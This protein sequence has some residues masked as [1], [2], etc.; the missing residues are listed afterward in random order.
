MQP[1]FSK[2]QVND[3]FYNNYV[4]HYNYFFHS[5]GG[6]LCSFSPCI[7]QV[8]R[9]CLKLTDLGFVYINTYECLQEELSVQYKILPVLDLDCL[10]NKVSITSNT[11][12][13]KFIS[14]I[15][16]IITFLQFSTIVFGR[17]LINISHGSF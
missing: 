15:N 11:L 7:E 12:K 4:D 16:F 5:S 8:Q 17:K 9:T 2:L 13:I 10:K 6:K 3:V 1:K 14:T